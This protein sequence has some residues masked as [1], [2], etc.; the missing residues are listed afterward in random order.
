[1]RLAFADRA[2]FY[3]DPAYTHVDVRRLLR[4]DYAAQ[5]RA[6]IRPDRAMEPPP[7]A[8]FSTTGDTTYLVAADADGMM[9][10]L[11]QSNYRGMGSGLVPDGLGF[12]LQDRGGLGH[13]KLMEARGQLLDLAAKDPRLTAVRQNGIP[14]VPQ[15]KVDLDWEKSG[16][17]GVS[18]SSLQNS[19]SAAFGS[20]YINDFIQGGNGSDR[21]TGGTGDDYLGGGGGSFLGS[22]NADT[23]VFFAG[24]GKDTIGDFNL[25]AGAS[26]HDVI[27]IH[28]IFADFDELM[29]HVTIEGSFT[30]IDTDGVNDKAGDVII[31]S[32]PGFTPY[33]PQ[34]ADFVFFP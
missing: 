2:R 29:D 32:P 25:L 12:M 13:E 34:A 18:V 1:M 27:E 33:T 11:I 8:G 15:Y 16:T 17:Q 24:H 3:G 21:I 7:H 26:E 14:D 9:V 28:G 4:D 22:T 20:A 10:S 19:I 31:I 6:L 23:F 5:R 30:Y